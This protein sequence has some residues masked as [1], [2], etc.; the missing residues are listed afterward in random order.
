MCCLQ[1]QSLKGRDRAYGLL[2]VSLRSGPNLSDEADG[3]GGSCNRCKSARV[4]HLSTEVT[5][6]SPANAKRPCFTAHDVA[7]ADAEV[8]VWAA[9][10]KS[11]DVQ[12]LLDRHL[13]L[14]FQRC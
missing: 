1:R 9:G 8:L 7:M 10:S 12:L 2:L 14:I 5:H 3:I 11:L 6:E 4:I 13:C